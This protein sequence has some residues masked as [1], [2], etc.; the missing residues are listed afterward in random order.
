MRETVSDYY[1]A[2][3]EKVYNAR[4]YLVLPMYSQ[5]PIGYIQQC[6]RIDH[7]SVKLRQPF[8][9]TAITTLEDYLAQAKVAGCEAHPE[10]LREGM[11]FYRAI[12]E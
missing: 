6:A 9:L 12:T 3:I 2:L 4:G 10:A 7:N 1:W 8:R 11:C 5:H